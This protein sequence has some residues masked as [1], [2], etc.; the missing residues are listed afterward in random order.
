ME[1]VCK[2][3]HVFYKKSECETCP[4]CDKNSKNVE[5]WMAQ[6]SAPARRALISHGIHEIHDL[7]QYSKMEIGEWHGIGPKAMELIS[8]LMDKE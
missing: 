1:K 2:K 4:I 7:H 6:F 3:G 8:R 5:S